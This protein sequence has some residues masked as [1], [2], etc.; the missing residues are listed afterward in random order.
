ML[1][2]PLV[3]AVVVC[4]T[5]AVLLLVL[6]A[7]TSAKVISDWRP[8]APTWEQL[9]LERRAEE[10]SLLGRWATTALVLGS[11]VLVVGLANVF[12]RIV[13]G[14][15]C[16]TGV[17]QATGGL[18]TRAL[19][20]RLLS[21]LILGAW[22]LVDHLDRSAPRSPLVMTS[23]R[24]L[25]FAIPVVAVAVFTTFSSLLSLDVL[26]PVDCCSVVFE[27]FRPVL[28]SI[29]SKGLPDVFLVWLCLGTGFALGLV[30]VWIAL[31]PFGAL[32]QSTMALGL[33]TLIWVPVAFLSMVNVFSA[34]HYGVLHHR[35]PWCLFLGENNLVGFFVFGALLVVL[36][37][38]L[39]APLAA[40]IVVTCPDLTEKARRR[41]RMGAIRTLVAMVSYAALAGG[42]ALA[43]RLA[44]GVWMG[45]N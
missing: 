23:A 34:Y 24:L 40:R 2:H 15:M 30:G 7:V 45:G 14:A 37:E 28:E 35:C 31:H 19:G 5:G 39:R 25:L 8:G 18:A 42:P 33:L 16:G 12:P 11:L 21:L 22:H 9:R 3:L 32:A 26:T 13:R 4:D 44:Y 10:S 36:F 20:L 38:G 29:T 27:Q 43:W 17:V 6:A 41:V 1:T